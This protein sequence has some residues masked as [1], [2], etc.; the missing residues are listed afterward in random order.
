MSADVIVSMS[1]RECDWG[2]GVPLEVRVSG[3]SVVSQW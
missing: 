3:E 2:Y 1:E